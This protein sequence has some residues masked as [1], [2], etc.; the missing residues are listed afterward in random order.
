VLVALLSLAPTPAQ[1]AAR[2]GLGRTTEVVDSGTARPPAHPIVSVPTS[3]SRRTPSA[4]P[5]PFSG[6]LAQGVSPT[7]RPLREGMRLSSADISWFGTSV[8][9]WAVGSLR[10]LVPGV[11]ID[12]GINR[13]PAFVEGRAMKDLTA[14]T[15]RRAV[16]LHLGDAGPVSAAALDRTLSRLGDRV[17]VVLVNSTARFAFVG[18]GNLTLADVAQH[19][20]NVVVADWKS[21]SAGHPD[22]FKDGLHLTAKGMPQY[23]LFVRRAVL[24]V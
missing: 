2:E 6:S 15:L 9:L 24:G 11:A 7:D 3:A 14:G 17:R 4:V 18:L 19:H 5:L 12:A 10:S 22:W 20:P 23:A 21:F 1:V 13:A 8:D 16:V